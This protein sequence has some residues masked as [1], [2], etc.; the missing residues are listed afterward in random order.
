[1]KIFRHNEMD[2]ITGT[3][4]L[5]SLSF[6]GTIGT[7]TRVLGMFSSLQDRTT[8]DS[9]GSIRLLTTEKL[10]SAATEVWVVDGFEKYREWMDGGNL[11]ERVT[12]STAFQRETLSEEH[13]LQ[14]LYYLR[15]REGGVP[16]SF[17]ESLRVV[18][19]FNALDLSRLCVLPSTVSERGP[20]NL[21]LPQNLTN[22]GGKVVLDRRGYH[23]VSLII[24]TGVFG[25]ETE[26]QF[27]ET[28]EAGFVFIASTIQGMPNL[29]ARLTTIG[30]PDAG[31]QIFCGTNN[32]F[33]A[34]WK[35]KDFIEFNELEKCLAVS[36]LPLVITANGSTNVLEVA[37]ILQCVSRVSNTFQRY[38]ASHP[39]DQGWYF[40]KKY[41]A[42]SGS[43][44]GLLDNNF[45]RYI[46]K[47]LKEA[48]QSVCGTPTVLCGFGTRLRLNI[49]EG[50]HTPQFI[51]RTFAS[52][53]AEKLDIIEDDFGIEEDRAESSEE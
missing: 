47:Q 51:V 34:L 33:A 37:F 3:S 40:M 50:T 6:A 21:T 19:A 43:S 24:E 45:F 46:G 32:C 23:I 28:E 16:L 39:G 15:A 12:M 35:W 27:E 25:P 2:D 18:S 48:V 9:S 31:G 1:M 22:I 49:P 30:D 38:E 42:L 26:E 7:S 8:F 41:L 14:F 13:V 17:A 52:S 4:R 53:I 20:R 10:N 29:L 11:R 36:A 5:V 44:G